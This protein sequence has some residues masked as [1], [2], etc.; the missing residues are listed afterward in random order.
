VTA[1]LVAEADDRVAGLCAIAVAGDEAEI[2]ALYVDPDRSRRGHGSALLEAAIATAREAGCRSL[3]LWV[4]PDNEAATAFYARF[5]LE[6]DG[7][8][9]IEE[10]TGA[11]V[12]RLSARVAAA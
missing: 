5:G 4:L 1:T 9:K 7:G 6:P 10:P 3:F 11:R 12:I 8:E 2:A